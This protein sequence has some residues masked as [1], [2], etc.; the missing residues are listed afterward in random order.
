MDKVSRIVHTKLSIL[1]F[2]LTRNLQRITPLRRKIRQY[3]VN[4][5]IIVC[6]FLHACIYFIYL[7]THETFIQHEQK[8][9]N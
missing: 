5:V 4:T 6:L 3:S 8:F 9:V 1:N 2:C 7:V